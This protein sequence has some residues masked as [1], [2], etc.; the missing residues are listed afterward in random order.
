MYYSSSKDLKDRERR[1]KEKG[2]KEKDRNHQPKSKVG[3]V[4]GMSTC[5]R[6]PHYESMCGMV[7]QPVTTYSESI[8]T[9]KIGTG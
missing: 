9:P 1:K 7:R 6:R 3:K 8:L 5:A 2:K 4:V